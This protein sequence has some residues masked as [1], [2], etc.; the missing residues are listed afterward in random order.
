MNMH[1]SCTTHVPQLLGSLAGSVRDAGVLY[2]GA[3][4]VCLQGPC[5]GGHEL[6]GCA[7]GGDGSLDVWTFGSKSLV[8]KKLRNYEKWMHALLFGSDQFLD[9]K[10]V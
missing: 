1:R 9:L 6:C 10:K 5:P 7:S 2:L 4:F 8:V 3:G